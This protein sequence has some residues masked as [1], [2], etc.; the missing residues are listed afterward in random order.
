MSGR[1]CIHSGWG[2][3]GWPAWHSR[4]PVAAWPDLR[5]PTGAAGPAPS[6]PPSRQFVPSDPGDM[7]SLFVLA[8]SLAL[9]SGEPL[10]HKL[11]KF[12]VSS[13]RLLVSAHL[14]PQSALSATRVHRPPGKMR[15]ECSWFHHPFTAVPQF[16]NSLIRERSGKVEY[17]LGASDAR[18]PNLGQSEGLSE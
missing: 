7:S 8:G 5:A 6:S 9:A 10:L 4:H 15:R 2:G 16:P 11:S 18:S 3:V 1:S 12:A 14:R 17:L 13:N